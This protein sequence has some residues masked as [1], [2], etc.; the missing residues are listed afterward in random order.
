MSEADRH[1]ARVHGDPGQTKADKARRKQARINELANLS[2]IPATT[3]RGLRDGSLVAVPAEPD[4]IITDAIREAWRNTRVS[5]V[6]GMSLEAQWRNGF[7]RE[8]A[9]YRAMLAAAQEQPR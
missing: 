3:L 4:E 8:I 2:G 6:C 7:A 1:M 5:G 9:A